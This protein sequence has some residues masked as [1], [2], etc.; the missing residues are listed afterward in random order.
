[1]VTRLGVSSWNGEKLP[2]IFKERSSQG[3]MVGE[4]ALVEGTSM[5]LGK[6]DFVDRRRKAPGGQL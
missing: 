3:L 5:S 4:G 2:P 1:M 6:T